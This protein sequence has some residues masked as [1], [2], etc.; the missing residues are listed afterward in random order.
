[1][2]GNMKNHIKLKT[3]FG[4]GVLLIL[5]GAMTI[6]SLFEIKIMPP[7]AADPLPPVVIT[8][9][10][11][12]NTEPG[13]PEWWLPEEPEPEEEPEDPPYPWWEWLPGYSIYE[14]IEFMTTTWV[15]Q[16]GPPV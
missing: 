12:N 16:I 2:V 15:Y 9:D 10:D 13:Y 6:P 3:I 7:V 4:A 1:M 8:G 11:L 14:M 5:L